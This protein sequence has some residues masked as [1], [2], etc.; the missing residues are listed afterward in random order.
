MS[1]PSARIAGVSFF[2]LGA[3]FLTVTMLAASIAP[4][5]DFHGGAISDLGVIDST[6]ALFNGLLVASGVLNAVGGWL[7]FRSH[8]RVLVLAPYA[9][10]SVGAIGAG[11]FPLSTGTPHSLFALVA[12]LAFNLE[13]LAT[14]TILAGPLRAVSITAGLIGLTAV[15]LMIV[16]DAGNAAAFGTI[17]HGG[18][19]RLIVYPAMLWLMALGGDLM[20]RTDSDVSRGSLGTR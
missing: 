2:L 15:A 16:G 11:V 17:G 9:V 19:E 7:F 3:G 4:G 14:A 5:Y 12:F 8:G 6:A 13:A 10:A 1:T 20:S 18:T